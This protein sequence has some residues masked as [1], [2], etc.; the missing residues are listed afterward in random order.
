MQKGRATLL[1]AS[2]L[3]AYL[4]VA[5]G[6]ASLLVP[7][8]DEPPYAVPCL[9]GLSLLLVQSVVALVLLAPERKRWWAPLNR[10]LPLLSF[11]V[12]LV[13]LALVVAGPDTRRA[14]LFVTYAAWTLYGG[15]EAST[16][17]AALHARRAPVG[18]AGALGAAAGLSGTGVLIFLA[19]VAS[20]LGVALVLAGVL[21]ATASAAVAGGAQHVLP[22]QGQP[23]ATQE[24]F[25]SELQL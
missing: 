9:V 18:V 21:L 11:L 5:G 13:A 24:S 3:P 12:A 16:A 10:L 4:L 7:S 1:H 25:D 22:D 8:D 23:V 2:S 20:S 15:A 14:G 6:V 19:D 17:L